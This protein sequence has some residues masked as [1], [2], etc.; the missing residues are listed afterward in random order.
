[1]KGLYLTTLLSAFIA[2]SPASAKGKEKHGTV[3]EAIEHKYRTLSH[4]AASV[5]AGGEAVAQTIRFIQPEDQVVENYGNLRQIALVRH[6]EPDLVKTGKFSFAEARKFL[7]DYD[8]VGIVSPE[9]PL[10]AIGNPDEVS[11]FCSSINRAR[12]TAQHLFGEDAAM[13]VSPD[14]REFETSLG[15]RGVSFKLPIKLWT[16]VARVKWILGAEKEGIESFA[17]AKA[18]ARKAAESLVNA[19]EED[20][21]AVLVAHGFLNRYVKKNLEEMGWRVVRDGGHGYL[22][23]TILV[24]MVD[25]AAETPT[26]LAMKVE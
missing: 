20:P 14:F 8:S 23:T 10:L 1:M 9:Q 24:K 7:V 11:I 19:T 6:G 15:K 17:D 12:A 21:K 5:E 16:A 2:L 13:T 4:D 25:E 18:R 22:G 3:I 26:Q